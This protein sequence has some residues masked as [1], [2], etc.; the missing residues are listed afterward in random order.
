MKTVLPLLIL[1][2]AGSLVAQVN[3][4]NHIG[5]MAAGTEDAFTKVP[6]PTIFL[7]R[8]LLNTSATSSFSVTFSSNFPDSAKTAFR[9]ADSIWSFLLVSS[10]IIHVSALWENLSSSILANGGPAAFYHDFTSAPQSNTFYPVALAE[11]I[12]GSDL[13]SADSADIIVHCNSTKSWYFGTDGNPHS[14]KYDFVS[15]ILHEL[16]HGFGFAPTFSIP[17]ST[18]WGQDSPNAFGMQGMLDPVSHIKYPTIYDRMCVVGRYYPNGTKLTTDFDSTLNLGHDL[19]SNNIFFDGSVNI[20]GDYAY[21]M[22]LDTVP[23]LYAPLTWNKFSISHLDSSAFP[24]GNTNSLMKRS[25]RPAEVIHSPGEVGLAML[26]DL[27]W[28]AN[29]LITVKSPTNGSVVRTGTHFMITYTDNSPGESV[30]PKLLRQGVDSQYY[31]LSNIITAYPYTRIDSIVNH[32]NWLVDSTLSDGNYEI[33][34]LDN[35]FGYGL[36]NSFTILN[37]P[38]VATPTFNLP[39]GDYDTAQ[40]VRISCSTQSATILYTTNGFNPD[41]NS[42][43]YDTATSIWVN[44]SE[45]VKARAFKS[46]SVSSDVA[47]ATYNIWT[48]PPPTVSLPSGA[49]L[50]PQNVIVGWPSGDTLVWDMTTDNSEPGDPKTGWWGSQGVSGWCTSSNDASCNTIRLRGN[51]T[52][53]EHLMTFHGNQWSPLVAVTYTPAPPLRIAQVDPNG[54]S[55]GTWALWQSNQWNPHPDTTIVRPSSPTTYTVLA[56]QGFK[57]GSMQ[58]YFSWNRSD[59]SA[60]VVNDAN[61]SVN[62]N[63]ASLLANFKSAYS[64]IV[65]KNVLVDAPGANGGTVGFRDPWLID[66][67]DSGHPP[68]SMNRGQGSAKWHDSLASGFQPDTTHLYNTF[69]Y[70]GVFLNQL[71]DV[72]N[73]AVPYYSVRVPQAQTIGNYQNCIF[74]GWLATAAT[75]A[76]FQYPTSTQTP[77]I[78][79]TA[80]D[81]LK[82]R[83]KAHLLSTTSTATGSNN[84]RKIIVVDGVAHAVYSDYNCI[85]YTR[86]DGSGWSGEMMLNDMPGNIFPATNPSIVAFTQQDGSKKIRVVWQMDY[87]GSPW[88]YYRDLIWSGGTWTLDWAD[89]LYQPDDYGETPAIASRRT[90]FNNYSQVVVAYKTQSGIV[91]SP[92]SDYY[93]PYLVP[94]TDSSSSC[95]SLEVGGD[96]AYYRTDFRLVYHQGTGS[97][98]YQDFRVNASAAS[99]YQ[100]TFGSPVNLTSGYFYA[101]S[102]NPSIAIAPGASD[103]SIFVC[104]DADSGSSHHVFLRQRTG[105]WPGTWSSP[106][107]F[108]HGTDRETNASVGVFHSPSGNVIINWKSGTEI[109]STYRPLTGGSWSSIVDLGPGFGPQVTPSV[110][111]GVS[112]L[113]EMWT[114][115]GVAPYPVNLLQVSS[116]S[117]PVLSS[118]VDNATNVSLGTALTWNAV[119]GATYALQVATDANFNTITTNATNI[120]ATQW[121][122]TLSYSTTYYWRA[123]ASNCAG[124][125]AWST[126]RSFTTKAQGGGGGGCCP[127]VFLWNDTSFVEDNNLLPQSEYP[128]NEGQDVTDYYELVREPTLKD[129]YYELE[130]REFEHEGSFIDWVQLFAVDHPSTDKIAVSSDGSII[131]YVT[132]YPLDGLIEADSSLVNQLRHFDGITYPERNGGRL[133]LKFKQNSDAFT[134]FANA[135]RGGVLLGGWVAHGY[136]VYQCQ[137]KEKVVGSASSGADGIGGSPQTFTFREQPTLVYVPLEKLEQS[138]TIHFGQKVAVDYV[139]LGLQVPQN[140]I[141]Q[142]L[143]LVSAVHSKKGNVVS[144]LSDSGGGYAT[145]QPGESIRLRYSATPV[146]PNTQRSFILVSHGHYQHLKDGSALEIPKSFLLGQNYPNPFNPQTTVSYQ[147]AEPSHVSIAIWNVLGEQVAKLVDENQDAGYYEQTWDGSNSSSG[148][149]YLRM[150]ATDA[151][152]K[153]LYQATKKIL[154]MK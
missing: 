24:V 143:S 72:N 92:S 101:N 62:Q 127:Y 124:T 63:T 130:F 69:N 14:L 8:N 87:Y 118:P 85:W 112:S 46:G 123:N 19:K 51:N 149:Y 98:M 115:G 86:N 54:N 152:G 38:K 36:S 154:L 59:T 61:I 34:M 110:Q 100:V 146:V 28:H 37:Q 10:K 66:S 89:F 125:S 99:G 58:K 151:Y 148:I 32:Y 141:R 4:I 5:G 145:L 30:W 91:V 96:S 52:V 129:G 147:V 94:G 31:P 135:T 2:F 21:K 116:P 90:G 57:P 102:A 55:F 22:N 60:V 49:Y 50:Y 104:W 80:N 33:E 76:Q 103:T 114:A 13:N 71:P 44:T 41:S 27:G 35:L 65:V 53:K 73:P 39:S 42:A 20:P 6:P 15:V 43:W 26:Q 108:T 131:E 11:A 93:P 84:Q 126:A 107:E 29:R 138:V 56:S 9:Y 137:P 77:V 18:T 139:N 16:A 3:T 75:P 144:E 25:L 78:F 1:V 105:A 117:A 74:M 81:T 82:A 132:P 40:A 88:I 113:W 142:E 121:Y 120:T 140:Y 68:A 153:L 95:P 83:Y 67:V 12:S 119:S 48:L 7:Y 64:G 23:K 70:K 17:D 136:S 109:L 128:G 134:T 122:P 133:T 111:S 47:S 97:I 106:V 79:R 150:V 45:T